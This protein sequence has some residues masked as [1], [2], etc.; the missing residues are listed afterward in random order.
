MGEGARQGWGLGGREEESS[1]AHYTQISP[2]SNWDSCCEAAM[3]TTTPPCGLSGII[4]LI[5][6]SVFMCK[7]ENKT[8]KVTVIFSKRKKDGK[9]EIYSKKNTTE[10][11]QGLKRSCC[12]IVCFF[13]KQ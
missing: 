5:K 1:H 12:F 9:A 11:V 7:T 13:S 8:L 10:I 4:T 6:K 3:L 2:W